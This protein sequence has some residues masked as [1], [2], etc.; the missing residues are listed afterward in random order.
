[1][2]NLLNGAV[3]QSCLVLI[4]A[5][6]G[7]FLAG[8][9]SS[10][11]PSPLSPMTTEVAELQN[12]SGCLD[13]GLLSEKIGK[14]KNFKKTLTDFKY[15]KSPSE[16]ML[17]SSKKTFDASNDNVNSYEG[18]SVTQD[19]CKTITLQS[20]DRS[21]E[22]LE[23]RIIEHSRTHLRFQVD[24]PVSADEGNIEETSISHDIAI[25]LIGID[26]M[27]VREIKPSIK[28]HLCDN[29]PEEERIQTTET[30]EIDF[31]DGTLPHSPQPSV[32]LKTIQ[33][34]VAQ[35]YEDEHPTV[36]QSPSPASEENSNANNEEANPSPR[37]SGSP[38]AKDLEEQYC[39][40]GL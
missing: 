17:Y 22:T 36:A 37:P 7:A 24:T 6:L 19:G 11:A 30:D 23:G 40:T 29:K 18:Q 16:S 32:E 39:K 10:N 26:R 27:T 28:A 35:A 38:Q 25:D 5:A 9:N 31:S 3:A 34:R 33:N 14:A 1:M 21:G 4:P 15:D 8:C 20:N 13:Y 12:S 2:K